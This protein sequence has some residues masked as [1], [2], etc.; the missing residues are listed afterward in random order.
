M[1]RKLYF[2]DD[3]R[4]HIQALIDHFKD[5]DDTPLT[6][7]EIIELTDFIKTQLI[8]SE[9]KNKDFPSRK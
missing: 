5:G 1:N 8:L 7:E 6:R 9:L 2:L 3:W 4:K